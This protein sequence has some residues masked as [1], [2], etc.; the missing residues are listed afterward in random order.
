MGKNVLRLA[1][2]IV[3]LVGLT[4]VAIGIIAF[5]LLALNTF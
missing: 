4:S 2:E 1:A 3:K 5:V